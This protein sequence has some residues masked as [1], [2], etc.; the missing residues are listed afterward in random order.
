LLSLPL[1]PLTYHV[2]LAKAT[3][4]RGENSANTSNLAKLTA[5][6]S[7]YWN[8]AVKNDFTSCGAQELSV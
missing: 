3:G 5:S 1:T 7:R 2:V 8:T 4:A 6:Q